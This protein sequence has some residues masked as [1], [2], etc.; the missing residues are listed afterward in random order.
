MPIIIW[1]VLTLHKFPIQKSE[2]TGVISLL[3]TN[4]LAIT[5]FSLLAVKKCNHKLIGGC[6]K[7]PR[8]NNQLC[9]RGR[10]KLRSNK[11]SISSKRSRKKRFSPK[12]AEAVHFY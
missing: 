4:Q 1:L 9:G 3:L 8:S 7:H 6:Y 12:P 11:E 10:M 5:L 2:I